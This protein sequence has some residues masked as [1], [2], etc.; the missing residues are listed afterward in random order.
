MGV[1]VARAQPR[2]PASPAAANKDWDS[3]T[4]FI[5]SFPPLLQS[6]LSPE[7]AASASLNDAE[8]LLCLPS[9]LL[10]P[11]ICQMKSWLKSLST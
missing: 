10:P 9:W 7:A 2:L 11:A 1:E 6:P 3:I 4:T 8:Q 5:L